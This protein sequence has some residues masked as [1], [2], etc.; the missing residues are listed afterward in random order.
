MKRYVPRPQTTLT[1]PCISPLFFKG[2]ISLAT[3]D[4]IVIIPPPPHPASALAAMSIGML[5]ARPHNSVPTVKKVIAIKAAGRLPM[6]S[7]NLPYRGVVAAK[8]RRYDVPSHD[9]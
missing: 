3:I 2:M 5:F 6:M 1:T 8:A 9:I 4:A 7:L